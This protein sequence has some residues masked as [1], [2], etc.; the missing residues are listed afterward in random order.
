M[1]TNDFVKALHYANLSEEI[2]KANEFNDNLLNN[3]QIKA[4]IYSELK[5]SKNEILYLKKH[6]LLKDS[7]LQQNHA[8]QMEE[9]KTQYETE[10]KETE[11]IK[12]SSDNKIQE[13]RLNRF[14]II[15]ISTIVVALLLIILAF[16]LIKNIRERK[17]AYIK[18][19]EKNI[20]IQKQGEQLNEQ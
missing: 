6:A 4:Q 9:L 2:N 1:L 11:I 14:I 17:K 18:L 10:K 12:L 16:F 8:I 20:E 13:L 15:I 5:D 7:L 3:Y 19:Q